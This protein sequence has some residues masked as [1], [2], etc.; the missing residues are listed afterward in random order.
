MIGSGGDVTP[1]GVDDS[2]VAAPALGNLAVGD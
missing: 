1:L 2:Q